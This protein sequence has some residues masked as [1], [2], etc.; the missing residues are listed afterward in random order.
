MSC[1]WEPGR[2]RTQKPRRN[3]CERRRSCEVG[4]ETERAPSL[5]S[6]PVPT[7][8]SMA[9]SLGA[10]MTGYAKGPWAAR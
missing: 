3:I 6:R 10:E 5:R 4:A 7:S 8:T 2:M 9:H 1:S